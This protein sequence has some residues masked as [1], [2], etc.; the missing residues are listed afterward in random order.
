MPEIFV[1]SEE[2]YRRLGVTVILGRTVI[3]VDAK[4]KGDQN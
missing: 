3:A 1:R 2:E 4:A